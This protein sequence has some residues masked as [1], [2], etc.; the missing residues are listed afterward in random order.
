MSTDEGINELLGDYTIKK[1]VFLLNPHSFWFCV[2]IVDFTVTVKKVSKLEYILS[3]LQKDLLRAVMIHFFM[4]N[5]F[6]VS[7]RQ[8]EDDELVH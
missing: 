6:L 7:E 4:G 3:K 5:I 1:V 8:L 2:S